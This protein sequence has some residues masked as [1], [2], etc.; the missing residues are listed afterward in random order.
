VNSVVYA[1]LAILGLTMLFFF[2]FQA[3]NQQTSMIVSTQDSEKRNQPKEGG[4]TSS[5]NSTQR[6]KKIEGKVVHFEKT[7]DPIT[8]VPEK[9]EGKK[10]YEICNLSSGIL[11]LFQ[12]NAMHSKLSS[13]LN[14]SRC[15]Q[16]K[17]IYGD[18]IRLESKATPIWYSM[19]ELSGPKV[20][21]SGLPKDLPPTLVGIGDLTK[22]I[23]ITIESKG[24]IEIP[25]III[26][27]DDGIFLEQDSFDSPG[28][29]SETVRAEQRGTLY[30]S[31]IWTEGG[32]QDLDLF[33]YNET[34]QEICRSTKVDT[35]S[36]ECKVEN[37]H[38]GVG[39]KATI[40]ISVHY[41]SGAVPVSYEVAVDVGE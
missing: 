10:Y 16:I 38:G 35:F 2:I 1:I 3:P 21:T 18:V 37:W 41:Y 6:D 4:S 39:Q 19:Q 40:Y 13:T 11:M 27:P 33:V 31:L 30:V 36:E 7:A 24:T 14:P 29:K 28:I 15:V 34:G 23:G 12:A 5:Q 20:V 25:S 32:R 9:F 26:P 8:I 22:D 17:V